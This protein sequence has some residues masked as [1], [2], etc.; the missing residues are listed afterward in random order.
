MEQRLV[1]NPHALQERAALINLYRGNP[2]LPTP[3]G[4][5]APLRRHQLWFIEHH[6][7]FVGLT[8]TPAI[9]ELKDDPEGHAEATRLWKEQ[10]SKP[11]VDPRV[12][13]NA[14]A[15][16]QRT[17]LAAAFAVL[18]PASK[19][20]PADPF[21]ARARGELQILTMLGV[22]RITGFGQVSASSAALRK[23]PEAVKAREEIEASSD[24]NVLGA[25]GDAL[26]RYAPSIR[27]T[28]SQYSGPDPTL[29]QDKFRDWA[30]QWLT[31]AHESAPQEDL[32][33]AGLIRAYERHT[34][35]DAQPA[36]QV[37]WLRKADA[38]AT[39]DE[40]RGSFLPR[41]AMAEFEAGDLA[42]AERVAERLLKLTENPRIRRPEFSHFAN[43]VLGRIAL[44][45]NDTAAAKE[46]LIASA[47][48]EGPNVNLAPNLTLAQDLLD[49]G[50]RAAVLE[51]LEK[52]R[53]FWRYDQGRL[54]HLKTVAKSPNGDLLA[55]WFPEG[56]QLIGRPAPAEFKSGDPTVLSFQTDGCVA[57]EENSRTL[58]KLAKEF[59]ARGVAFRSVDGRQERAM[60]AAYMIESYPS[61]VTIDREGKVAGYAIG[62]TPEVTLRRE[63]DAALQG[64]PP[65]AGVS[66]SAPIPR[67]AVEIANGKATLAWDA[68]E[69]AESYVVQWQS[70]R[71]GDFVR[72]VPTRETSA[73]LDLPKGVT[74]RWRVQAVAPF[75]PPGKLSAWQ[76][77]PAQ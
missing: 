65:R 75:G 10:A 55:N 43:T 2:T 64:A 73:L 21:L 27:Q 37:K 48:V 9:I 71:D 68:V 32:W 67:P 51:F 46:R 30:E 42:A 62:N 13:A 66:L 57:C 5:R 11:G 1:E 7:E 53:A 29:D 28:F 22:T 59:S 47:K 25:A 3:E 50:E 23:S 17:D 19:V 58:D 54:D 49:A 69:G 15:F 26:L 77:V 38:L 35:G 74:L 60:A 4:N 40:Q 44:E 45:R 33:T 63:I 18:E 36:E 24:P 20:H 76:D 8:R 70:D 12:V 14:V 41:L 52:C 6:P 61:V 34:F 16:F 31:K 72:I 56:R 39:R